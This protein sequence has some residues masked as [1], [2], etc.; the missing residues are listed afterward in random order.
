MEVKLIRT[1]SQEIL[2]SSRNGDPTI[3]KIDDT[4]SN[5]VEIRGPAGFLD[6]IPDVNDVSDLRI[7]FIKYIASPYLHKPKINKY[8]D[9]PVVVFELMDAN[10]NRIDV[11]I[12]KKT[13]KTGFI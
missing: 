12:S 2:N 1:L 13:D 9:S 11:N 10:T 7:E 3:F 5:N 4:N 6:G 8:I